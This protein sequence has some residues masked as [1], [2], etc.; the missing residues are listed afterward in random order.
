MSGERGSKQLDGQYPGPTGP[1]QSFVG[2]ITPSDTAVFDPPLRGIRVGAAGAGTL[3]VLY[4]GDGAATGPIL[5]S[6]DAGL[7]EFTR[8]DSGSFLADGFAAGQSVVTTAFPSGGNNTTKTIA[9]VSADG[10]R[11]TVTNLAGLVTETGTGD[12]TATVSANKDTIPATEAANG[13]LLRDKLI[14]MVFAT[15]TTATGLV[16]YR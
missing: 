1:L 2:A 10:R 11:Y 7:G 14:R 8:H 3:A 16:G 12:E 6:V 15:G 9:A 13:A 4:A 5:M